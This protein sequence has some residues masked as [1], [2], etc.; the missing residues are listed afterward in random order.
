MSSETFLD[1]RQI[2]ALYRP[3]PTFAEWQETPVDLDRW[4]RYVQMVP[5]KESLTPERLARARDILTRAAAID[6]GAI[7]G[8]YD[9]D[10]GFTISIAFQTVLWTQA[11]ASKGEPARALIESQLRA[12][13]SV[14][15]LATGSTPIVEAWIRQLH[16]ELCESQPTYRALTAAGWQNLPLPVGE[17][18]VLPNHV[19]DRHGERHA[20]APV[21]EVP[22][23][24]H[25]LVEQLNSEE[26]RQA[27]PALQASYAH[28]S[29]VA[30]HPFADGNGRVSR[31]LASVFTYRECSTPLLILED[32]KLAYITVLAEADHLDYR[33]FVD[34]I[35][36]RAFDAIYFT[37][38]SL[39]TANMPSPQEA[40]QRLRR[41]FETSRGYSHAEVEKA[42]H[43]L[44]ALVLQEIERQLQ[45]LGSTAFSFTVV[46][47]A[48]SSKVREEG[49][50]APAA[51]AR[52]LIRLKLSAKAPASVT[53]ELTL[54]TGIPV[55]TTDDGEFIMVDSSGSIR[56]TAR[57]GDLMPEP[58]TAFQLRLR[59]MV[60]GVLGR[61]LERLADEAAEHMKRLG[62]RVSEE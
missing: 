5:S 23:E 61:V 41:L 39:E 53:E 3:I 10:A 9:V 1:P 62:Y 30:I 25:R 7:E 18:K 2:D 44:Q 51:E 27:H 59:M 19:I 47:Q 14:I 22:M 50:R 16:R 6:T 20:Y 34:F 38:T 15:D 29:L 52:R 26:F 33:P 55:D 4:N 43:Q 45:E 42:A 17:Y 11:L 32:Q 60:E 8:L 37:R 58:S 40:E 24:M 36:E 31:A 56:L 21:D 57:I 48:G 12:Y 54:S 28:Y 13:E 46:F 49:I 35:A